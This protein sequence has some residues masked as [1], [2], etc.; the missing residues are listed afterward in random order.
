MCLE[1][2]VSGEKFDQNAADTPNIAGEAPAEIQDDFRRAVVAGRHDGGVVF[3]VESGRTKIDQSDLTV[4]ENATLPSIA[5]CSMGG[6]GDCAVVSESLVGV[7]NKQNVF[8]F[9]IGVDEIEVMEDWEI[10]L[11]P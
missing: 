3:V 6:G 11:K 1:E 8:G 9:K 10:S 4:E 5:V 7:A 2:S